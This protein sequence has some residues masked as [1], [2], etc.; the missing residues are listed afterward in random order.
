MRFATLAV[1]TRHSETETV[2]TLA[3][4]DGPIASTRNLDTASV[5]NHYLNPA[6]PP[7]TTRE[8]FSRWPRAEPGHLLDMLVVC[9]D[10]IIRRR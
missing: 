9:K 5:W 3:D 4:D 2:H 7:L 1:S 10:G 8:L 6:Q